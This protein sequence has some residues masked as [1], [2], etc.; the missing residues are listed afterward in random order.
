MNTIIQ[1]GEVKEFQQDIDK[2]YEQNVNRK[3]EDVLSRKQEIK[4]GM[5]KKDKDLTIAKINSINI[6]MFICLLIVLIAGFLMIFYKV[7]DKS[8]IVVNVDTKPFVTE[9]SNINDNIKS[10]DKKIE[11]AKEETNIKMTS[12]LYDLEKNIIDDINKKQRIVVQPKNY[13]TY[14]HKLTLFPVTN[15]PLLV[16]KHKRK[17]LTN[18]IQTSKPISANDS[19]SSHIDA[20]TPINKPIE[21]NNKD[22]K[23]NTL[24]GFKPLGTAPNGTTFN[25]NPKTGQSYES[26]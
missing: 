8:N 5:I 13:I 18:V 23:A 2:E 20:S 24:E 11:D 19:T 10:L 17:R 25:Y 6:M 7:S 4:R 16:T 3:I 22:I 26:K 14:K 9:A 12:L 21:T 1:D 15:K